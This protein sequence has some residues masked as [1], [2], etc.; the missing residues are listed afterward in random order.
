MKW[1]ASGNTSELMDREREAMEGEEAESLLRKKRREV[2]DEARLEDGMYH[3]T[4]SYKN[5]IVKEKEIPKAMRRGPQRGQNTIKTVTLMDYQPDVCKDYK[6]AFIQG[7]HRR[8]QV[9][10]N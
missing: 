6:G 3:G 5:H 10:V 7:P 4:Q 2:E 1:K 8:L 9:I